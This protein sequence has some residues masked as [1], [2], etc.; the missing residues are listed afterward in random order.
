[1]ER[2]IDEAAFDIGQELQRG[3]MSFFGIP[4]W[5]K[6]EGRKLVFRHNQI[7]SAAQLE[8]LKGMGVI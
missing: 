6:D 5:L 7:D 2:A 4:V 1:M 3:A 8:I